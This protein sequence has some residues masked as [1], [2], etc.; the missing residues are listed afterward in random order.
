MISTLGRHAQ[1]HG[2]CPR[3]GRLVPVLRRAAL[4][5]ALATTLVVPA[6]R[7][8]T[9]AGAFTPA[10]LYFPSVQ[11]LNG[12]SSDAVL[13][14]RNTSASPLQVAS[15]SMLG[16]DPSS[17][18]VTSDDCTGTT[19]APGG[20]CLFGL[21][22]VPSHVGPLGAA[23]AV[24][25]DGEADPLPAQLAGV[26][27][28]PPRPDAGVNLSPPTISGTAEEGKILSC[29]PGT[30]SDPTATFD[31]FWSRGGLGIPDANGQ[32]YTLQYDDVGFD[33]ACR[34]QAST[35]GGL[36]AAVS[37]SVVPV[38]KLAPTCT[39]SAA[40]QHLPTVLAKGFQVTA[41]CSEPVTANFL[42]TVSDKDR[43][44]YG[45]S[46]VGIGR[47]TGESFTSAGAHKLRIPL[48]GSDAA[49]LAKA[50]RLTITAKL[51]ASDR[52]KLESKKAQASAIAKR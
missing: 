23:L 36:V 49:R 22:F 13:E 37:A 29:A 28:T 18:T 17:F 21:R 48:D 46:S 1:N 47:L 41:T 34:A 4:V 3:A 32:S 51:T 15:W 33:V 50:K 39:L 5:A 45:L 26:G 19:V 52:V 43:E 6:A 8:Q 30:W 25:T 10:L 16:L 11:V 27:L 42:L 44:T 9:P 24:K 14:L 40:G 38:D 2:L 31:Y 12:A 35:A 7:A 20:S